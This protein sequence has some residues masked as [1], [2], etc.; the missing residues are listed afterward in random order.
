M[1]ITTLI[2]AY[3]VRYLE[4]V[5]VSLK[6]QSLRP[7]RIIISDDSPDRAFITAFQADEIKSAAQGLDVEVIEGPRAG[8]LANC[9]HLLDV[10]NGATPLVHLLFDDDIIYPEFYSI[11]AAA[12]ESGM[13]DCSVSRRWTALESG[14][15]VS[16]LERPR[17]VAQHP[18]RLMSLASDTLFSLTIPGCQNW[19]GEYSNAVINREA[20]N[21]IMET[22]MAGV[23]YEGLGDIGLFLAASL[24]KP[25]CYINDPL[26]FFRTH[27]Q[28]VSQQ[29]SGHAFKLAV[30]AWAA[31]A[32]AGYRIGKLSQE[33]A[34]QCFQMVSDTLLRG[35]KDVPEMVRFSSL[36]RELAAGVPSSEEKFVQHWHA[37]VPGT[38]GE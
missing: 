21:L 4:E 3:K 20:A 38:S 24:K 29:T 2:P 12:H 19:L 32:V 14:Q 18:Q 36:L 34:A 7:E 30:L 11:H 37:F 13:F 31:L 23:S 22:Q 27:A 8:G 35:Y 28:Q 6:H 17:M 26:G 9:R 1:A 16:Q 5:L 25:V 15:P 10:W 33:Q